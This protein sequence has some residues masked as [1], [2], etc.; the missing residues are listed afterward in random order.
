MWFSDFNQEVATNVE[1]DHREDEVKYYQEL[2]KD[3][4]VTPDD[5]TLDKN[6]VL[7]PGKNKDHWRIIDFF[8]PIYNSD[9]SKNMLAKFRLHVFLKQPLYTIECL[10]KKELYDDLQQV[11]NVWPFIHQRKFLRR[12]LRMLTKMS[13]TIDMLNCPIGFVNDDNWKHLHS[14]C[15]LFSRQKL[16][17]RDFTQHDYYGNMFQWSIH[18]MKTKLPINLLLMNYEFVSTSS[19]KKF[20]RACAMGVFDAKLTKWMNDTNS[21]LPQEN[22]IEQES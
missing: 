5:Y 12:Q 9:K 16:T 2:F 19:K 17:V 18:S 14:E 13:P 8:L 11:V 22:D 10:N 3:N 7:F 20:V 4:S 6:G 1:F 21:D 15:Y